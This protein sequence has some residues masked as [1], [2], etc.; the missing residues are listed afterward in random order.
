MRGY[1]LFE[2]TTD[3]PKLATAIEFIRRG[4][5]SGALKPLIGKTFDLADIASTHEYMESNAP[6]G[7][8]I[9][10]VPH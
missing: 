7:K 3:P 5:E 4:L 10:R 8:I 9:V 2:I 6:F 1:D